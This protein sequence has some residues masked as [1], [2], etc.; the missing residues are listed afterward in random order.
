MDAEREKG[1]HVVLG[2]AVK[3]NV[4]SNPNLSNII[5]E[6]LGNEAEDTTVNFTDLGIELHSDTC[7][8]DSENENE[9]Y[10]D[11]LPVIEP[12]QIP[13]S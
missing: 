4:P 13:N 2:A 10:N 6:I 11:Y 1:K 12:L 8:S 3:A 5:E 9:D 7:S